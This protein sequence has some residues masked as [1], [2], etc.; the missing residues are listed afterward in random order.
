MY[1]QQRTPAVFPLF[2]RLQPVLAKLARIVKF[3]RADVAD[4]RNTEL[5][6]H[7][8]YDVGEIDYDP[9]RIRSS[10][11]PNSYES[12]FWLHHYTR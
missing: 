5:A 7:L 9:D 8:Q 1:I 4:R 3:I 12:Q 2:F 10:D 11:K 6:L